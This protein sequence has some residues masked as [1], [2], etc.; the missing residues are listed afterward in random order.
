M[1]NTIRRRRA[2]EFDRDVAEAAA[3][4]SPFDDCSSY[5]N[6]GGKTSGGG[7]YGYSD[8]SH[9]TFQL[10][11]LQPHDG[12]YDMTEM[13]QYDPY[14]AGAASL[15]AATAVGRSRSRKDSEPGAPG[16]AGVGAG[17]LDREQARSVSCL[18]RAWTQ[19]P[20]PPP[21]LQGRNSTIRSTRGTNQDVLEAVGL[22]GP[23]AAAIAS[24]D[25]NNGG[26]ALSLPVSPRKVPRIPTRMAG[27][28]SDL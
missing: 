7:G 22:T 16:I 17:T 11:P 27:R 25:F 13:S 15:A 26:G 23:S 24:N 10:P 18:C 1:V 9:G 14:A 19:P 5:P 2:Q 28:N 20:Q 4:R 12:P 3:A 6:A 8:N 21:E